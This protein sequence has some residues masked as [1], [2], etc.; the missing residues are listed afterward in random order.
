LAAFNVKSHTHHRQQIANIL[1]SDGHA[2]SQPN[3]NGR[4]TADL[5]SYGDIHD[6]FDRILKILEE[7]DREE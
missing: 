7:A 3:T 1:F 6:A 2:L 4:F 5:S